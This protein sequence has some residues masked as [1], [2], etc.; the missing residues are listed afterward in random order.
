MA[1][2]EPEPESVHVQVSAEYAAAHGKT[3]Q[4]L[5]QQLVEELTGQISSYPS[6]ELVAE[7]VPTNE[8]EQEPPDEAL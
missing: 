3:I 6:P 7:P 1:N 8:D 2:R 4:A 5:E